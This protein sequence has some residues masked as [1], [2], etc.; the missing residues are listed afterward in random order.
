MQ[1]DDQ[2]AA[3]RHHPLRYALFTTNS[4]SGFPG[5]PWNQPLARDHDYRSLESWMNLARALEAAR[6]DTIFWAD[7]SGIYDVFE[8]SRDATVRHA[9][10]F[11]INDPSALVSALATVTEHLGFA[12]SANVIQEP[13]FSFARR[14]ATLDHLTKGRVAWNIVT[15]FQESAWRNVGHETAAGHAERY[16]RAEEYVDV[17]YKLLEGSWEDHALVRDLESGVYA[18]PSAIEAID[19][20]GGFYKSAGPAITEPS[21]QRLPVLFQAGS[22][23]D[24]RAFA[25]KNAEAIFIG[26]KNPRGAAS[27]VEDMRELITSMGRHAGDLMVFQQLSCIVGATEAEAQEKAEALKEAV[28]DEANL[29]YTS[30]TMG[31]DLS[32]VDLDTPLGQLDTDAMQG[33]LRAL[34]EAAPNKEWTFREVVSSLTAPQVVGTGE[35]VA[36][37]VETYAAAGVRGMNVAFLNGL[38]ELKDFAKYAVPELQRR[39]LMQT[40]YAP[41]TL[42]E[43]W[44]GS[45]RVN[46][47][48]PA[49][50]YRR[51]AAGDDGGS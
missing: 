33:K 7:H 13:P 31:L 5:S 9:V 14:I 19:H 17:V 4:P 10:Q 49:A 45:A 23:K 12:F 30:A 27:V 36:D 3:Q 29:A 21:P 16:E 20:K 32:E 46:E 8:G 38:G 41:G 2:D 44:L 51:D 22:S 50:S 42:R 39:G 37:Y 11:P 48:H 15:S 24:G 34:V 1:N 43:K 35:Q 6:F 18:D 28:S 25:A 26:A 47:R 40:E